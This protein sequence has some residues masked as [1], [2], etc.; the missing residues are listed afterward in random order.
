MAN[1]NHQVLKKRA[2]RRELYCD[3]WFLE[4]TAPDQQKLADRRWGLKIT[5]SFGWNPGGL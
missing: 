5:P 4:G 3:D 2:Q 1:Q